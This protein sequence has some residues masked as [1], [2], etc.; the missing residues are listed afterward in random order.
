M[1]R[2]KKT[3]IKNEKEIVDIVGSL[4]KT[5]VR[6]KNVN[7]TE[8]Q[9]ELLKLVFDK[10]TKIIFISGPAG[11]SKTFMAI[12]G[13]LQLFN[14]DNSY[15]LSYV[16]TIIESADRGMGAL[17]G[18]IDEKFDPFM[19]P[20]NDKLFELVK[21]E[22]I[23]F[24]KE[25]KIINAMPIN[26]LRGANW[27]NQIVVADESQNFS[28]KELITLI[29]RIGEGTKLFICGDPMQSDINGRSG[30][31]KIRDIFNNEES[32]EQGIHSFEF[33]YE[34]IMRSEILK[35][36]IKKLDEK[37]SEREKSGSSNAKRP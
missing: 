22:D 6:V 17:P 37:E 14:M 9:K 16:R 23:N 8:K 32:A 35:F 33:T 15:S 5:K 18:H 1:P 13:A 29:T 4:G 12:Y 20:L 25:K 19:M 7:F 26:Y 30:F 31:N 24:L 2:R 21:P 28:S 11:T 36:I 3:E 27:T 34:D 10:N